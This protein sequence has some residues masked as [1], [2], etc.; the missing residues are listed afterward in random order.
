MGYKCVIA[1]GVLAA[2]CIYQ[3]L[4]YPIPQEG[5]GRE[6]GWTGREYLHAALGVAALFSSVTTLL[7]CVCCKRA[8]GFKHSDS[9][10]QELGSVSSRIE[11]STSTINH[12]PR[13]EFTLFPP[14]GISQLS[15]STTQINFEPLPD[16]RPRSG[17]RREHQITD[18]TLPASFPA[19]LSTGL[20]TDEWFAEPHQN[21]PRNQLQYVKEIGKGWFGHVLEGRATGIF[22]DHTKGESPHSSTVRPNA[23]YRGQTPVAVKVLREDATPT[24]QMYFL[25]ELRPYRQLS[26]PNLLKVLAH[27][28]ETEPFLILL[29]LCP[30]G[31]LKAVVRQEKN[32][33]EATLLRM[34]LNVAAGLMHMHAHSFIHTD[35]AARNCL[36]DEDYTV[37]IGDYGCNIDY[38][39]NEYYCAG[40]VALPL[41]WCAPETLKCTD[42]TIETKEVTK[43]ANVW[44]FGIIMWEIASRGMMPYTHLDDDHVIQQVIV[45]ESCI[46]EPPKAVQL[47]AE[48]IYN[49]M[50]LCWGS[51]SS[52]PCMTHIHSLLMHLWDNLSVVSHDTASMSDFELRWNQLQQQRPQDH[53]IVH[54][55]NTTDLRFDS[56]FSLSNRQQLGG[57]MSPSLQ[58]LHGSVED[59]DAKMA[60][61]FGSALPSWLGME[62]GQPMDSLTREITDAILK[63][64]DYLAGEKSEPST[65]EASPEKGGVNFK[66]GKDSFVSN[67]PNSKLVRSSTLSVEEGSGHPSLARTLSDGEDEGFTMRLEQGEFSEMVRLKS[68]SV[69]DFMKLTVVDDGSDSDNAS[70]RNSLALEPVKK[71]LAQEKSYSSEGNIR[72]ALRDDKFMGE[73][74]RLQA[75]HRYSIITEASRENASSIEYRNQDFSFDK[76]LNENSEDGSTDKLATSV[77]SDN[78]NNF[79][80][81]HQSEADPFLGEVISSEDTE[82]KKIQLSK[83]LEESPPSELYDA[84]SEQKPL[85]ASPDCVVSSR[86]PKPVAL[87]DIVVHDASVKLSTPSPPPVESP[88]KVINSNQPREFRFVFGEEE[89]AALYASDPAYENHS[90]TQTQKDSVVF[91]DNIKKAEVKDIGGGWML[92]RNK[93]NSQSSED[94]NNIDPIL[95]NQRSAVQTGEESCKSTELNKFLDYVQEKTRQ[96]LTSTPLKND[97]D[98]TREMETVDGKMDSSP[99]TDGFSVHDS[100]YEG[101]QEMSSSVIAVDKDNSKVKQRLVFGFNKDE[102]KDTDN[103]QKDDQ[104]CEDKKDAEIATQIPSYKPEEIVEGEEVVIGA[105]EHYSL[106]LYRAIKSPESIKCKEENTQYSAAPK[107]GHP[108]DN[109]NDRELAGIEFDLEQWDKFLGSTMNEDLVSSDTIF[110]EISN[111]KTNIKSDIASDI[112]GS[113]FDRSENVIANKVEDCP[114][115]SDLR[116]DLSSTF[117]H[118]T[119]NEI[120]D[121]MKHNESGVSEVDAHR[122]KVDTDV[123]FSSDSSSS[124]TKHSDALAQKLSMEFHEPF[125]NASIESSVCDRDQIMKFSDESYLTAESRPVTREMYTSGEVS[126]LYKTATLLSEEEV[127]QTPLLDVNSINHREW[128]SSEGS[129]TDDTRSL[130]NSYV[131]IDTPSDSYTY[132][133]EDSIDCTFEVMDHNEINQLAKQNKDIK[134]TAGKECEIADS[135]TVSSCQLPEILSSDEKSVIKSD[136]S[137]S[138]Q[139]FSV[140]K[141][142]AVH[143]DKELKIELGLQIMPSEEKELP[144]KSFTTELGNHNLVNQNGDALKPE[145][146]DLDSQVNLIKEEDDLSPSAYQ[147]RIRGDDCWSSQESQDSAVENDEAEN[148]DFWQQQMVAWQEAAFQ[149]RQLLQEAADG[150]N[151]FDGKL[152]GSQE[153]LEAS[154]RS[155]TS[156][157]KSPYSSTDMLNLDDEGT[158]VSYNTTDDEEVL[159]YKPEDINALRAELSLKLGGVQEKEE[160]EPEE[161]DDVPS[162][163]RDNV[164]IN[165]RGIITTTLSPIKEESFLEDYDSPAR[166]LSNKSITEDPSIEFHESISENLFLDDSKEIDGT[167]V[168]HEAVNEHALKK[169][170][171]GLSELAFSGDFEEG[172]ILTEDE[173]NEESK[174]LDSSDT[175]DRLHVSSSLDVCS[176]GKVDSLTENIHDSLIL[177]DLEEESG[178]S[179][180]QIYNS[181]NDGDGE[182]VL[183]VDTE[184]NEATIV[185]G[186]K[187]RSHLAF[188]IDQLEQ[189]EITDVEIFAYED[190]D[191]VAPESIPSLGGSRFD[192][193]RYREKCLSEGQSTEKPIE[194]VEGSAFEGDTDSK[195]EIAFVLTGTLG[196]KENLDRRKEQDALEKSP[197]GIQVPHYHSYFTSALSSISHPNASIEDPPLFEQ[198]EHISLPYDVNYPAAGENIEDFS[199]KDDEDEPKPNEVSGEEIVRN[200]KAKEEDEAEAPI[201]LS[202]LGRLYSDESEESNEKSTKSHKAR[203]AT[204]LSDSESEDEAEQPMTRPKTPE[205]GDLN[206]MTSAE[207]LSSK[208]YQISDQEEI[209]ELIEVGSL[210]DE[211]SDENEEE[212]PGFGSGKFSQVDFHTTQDPRYTPDWESDSDSDG[213]SSSTS[214][215]FMW[216]EEEEKDDDKE[217]V[218]NKEKPGEPCQQSNYMLNVIEEEAE[219][220]LEDEE[221]S[222]SDD[223]ESGEE[224]F[225]PSKWNRDL[226]PS[227][228]L[229]MS[230]ENRSTLKKSVRW[231][232]QRHHRVYEY[233]PEPRSWEPTPT[234]PHQRRSWGRSSL[235]YLS[236]ADWELG[237]DEFIADDTGDMEDY[238]YRKPIRPAPPPP[239]YSLGSVSYDDTSDGFLVDNGE[240]FIRSSASP[241]TFTSSS[242]SASDFF[243]ASHPS[244]Y[245]VI[246]GGSS[247]NTA[248]SDAL[249]TELLDTMVTKPNGVFND[250]QD[251]GEPTLGDDSSQSSPTNTVLGQLRHTRDKLRLEIPTISLAS[252]SEEDTVF[253]VENGENSVKEH[254]G[255]DT[256]TPGIN[257]GRPEPEVSEV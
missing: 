78:S 200:N 116:Q 149:T 187:P 43:P 2:G 11:G 199:D 14:A 41:R 194:D 185:E 132:R 148:G 37:K 61:K 163:E 63:L 153:D 207:V 173:S 215:E 190:S 201:K 108:K 17:S 104:S 208:K 224:E 125:H 162:G 174:T 168:I 249:P 84:P 75:E 120:S 30:K 131:I 134:E 69:Q 222:C 183:V 175:V 160:M 76:S 239:I 247:Q 171:P 25:H 145:S 246:F 140:E 32:L 146:F 93:T 217:D 129:K 87:P 85:P 23:L 64:D 56:D 70:Q 221:G 35:L 119:C 150:N 231:K 181:K 167:F 102:M 53:S 86:E 66:L 235:D 245:D 18:K 156:S 33:T 218:M 38:Y 198:V 210:C 5:L 177:E 31:D 226:L 68:Q 29:Q 172:I 202:F 103:E 253:T 22:S 133:R 15:V 157:T 176:Q 49:I 252:A 77:E 74:E 52:R 230:P 219:E 114:S 137:D 164:V 139:D 256:T 62:P 255:Q 161:P 136:A 100:S 107:D 65:T 105:L 8:A 126:D 155:D 216:R 44:S 115:I 212:G 98:D 165:Y 54:A 88:P 213:E 57:A 81:K 225:T 20:P 71:P 197:Q 10:L 209:E 117:E 170:E 97:E 123:F 242:F 26:H 135:S 67:P 50:K 195:P 118:S 169:M 47:H 188:I 128:S 179:S 60:A 228:S 40:E 227:R 82:E 152:K 106:E 180:I 94:S 36:V 223:S 166:R 158:Y 80:D 21:F 250:P 58:N 28:L 89:S 244:E 24:E 13:E 232:R 73:I 193:M 206:Q 95:N 90:D 101:D 16:I 189:P 214:G 110:K 72:E 141:D 233:P 51:E 184:T 121:I 203:E 59:L 248:L 196:S 55:G 130:G 7:A 241:F 243:P 6:G 205:P 27:C 91:S 238:V 143:N 46:L 113:T 236:L 159:G 12:G 182:D 79:N 42:T 112:L 48:K 229:L 254:N 142:K 191:D 3:A 9:G 96:R 19:Q 99:F 122:P 127:K 151:T 109:E 240:F 1:L 220:D 83:E 92:E 34:T 124:C 147:Y 138:V 211:D 192:E 111:D 257:L 234:Q 237:T 154:P 144:V 186:G 178:P 45:D 4:A 251:A 204:L 39:K